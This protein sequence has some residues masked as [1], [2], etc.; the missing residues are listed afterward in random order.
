M[1][2]PESAAESRVEASPD[3]GDA[4]EVEDR[5]EIDGP[6][7]LVFV[8]Y[9]VEPDQ[10]L[11]EAL[12]D[13]IEGAIDPPPK[14]FVSGAGGLRPSSLPYPTQLQLA[15]TEAV[16]FVGVITNASK[17]RAW[18]HFEAG[19]AWGRGKMYAPVLIDVA[20][21]ELES[22]IA[23]YQATKSSDLDAMR[24]LIGDIA[25]AVGGAAKPRFGQRLVPFS[26]AVAKY[27]TGAA[28]S[29]SEEAF[30]WPADPHDAVELAGYLLDSKREE[31][32]AKLKELEN[33]PQF[34]SY[35]R[36]V[37]IAFQ[38]KRDASERLLALEQLQ[39]EDR[40]HP[41]YKFWHGSL[42]SNPLRAVEELQRY[43]ETPGAKGRWIAF[44]RL[45]RLECE[46]GRE[47]DAL[48]RTLAALGDNDRTLREKAA[49]VYCERWPKA[50]PIARLSAIAAGLMG[51]WTGDLL[52]VAADLANEHEWSSLAVYFAR[53]YA[54]KA[55][56]GA[57][58]NT[59]GIALDRAGL[60][61]PAY[62]AF[63]RAAA[64]GVSV[65]KANMASLLSRGPVASAGRDILVE[66]TGAFDSASPAYPHQLR[67]NIEKTLSKERE[68]ADVLEENGRRLYR[69][70]CVMV[71]EGLGSQAGHMTLPGKYLVAGQV[72]EIELD[73]GG[74]ATQ[75]GSGGKT[76]LGP[77]PER[78]AGIF[79]GFALVGSRREKG[80]LLLLPRPYGFLAL[81]TEG[82]EGAW[83]KWER[84]VEPQPALGDT[85][86]V[87]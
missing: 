18:I 33:D 6:R 67:S 48:A 54:E 31:A 38:F 42:E 32:E 26:R 10:P 37:R 22:T 62:E 5:S 50:S 58:I 43:Y 17:D 13:L 39:E 25:S 80:F 47:D 65:A 57:S 53:R 63:K 41:E 23:I 56:D 12:A 74:T 28:P 36:I 55:K 30:R 86:S 52:K 83:V 72:I 8:S 59:E 34:A 4:P 24:L 11:A 75:K 15:A 27:T 81:S 64:D 69:K 87:A 20:P 60:F 40:A 21:S 9:R 7:P 49:R 79:P 19:A 51:S 45:V 77:I 85:S 14:V 82:G 66:H 3:I 1:V 44:G 78:Y 61:S 76:F 71:S 46:M 35:A 29:E 68:D 84:Q 73:E 70:L 16:A 2:D